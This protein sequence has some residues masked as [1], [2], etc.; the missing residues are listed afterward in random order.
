[1][2]VALL[3]RALVH[4]VAW[5]P[6]KPHL[7]IRCG[8]LLLGDFVQF[9]SEIPAE[10]V[11]AVGLGR[12]LAGAD[13]ASELGRDLGHITDAHRRI[14]SANVNHAPGFYAMQPSIAVNRRGTGEF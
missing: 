3:D 6:E 11:D 14:D 9:E 13:C 8:G 12:V 1:V 4:H 7:D 2:D 5:N 10:H